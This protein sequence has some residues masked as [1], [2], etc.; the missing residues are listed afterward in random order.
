VLSR[1]PSIFLSALVLAC[2]GFDAAPAHAEPTLLVTLDYRVDPAL[3][4]CPDEAAFKAM[5][6]G[7]L[8]YDAFRPRAPDRVIAHLQA[9][10]DGL[11]GAIE[12]RDA[13]GVARGQRDLT[14]KSGNCAELARTMSFAIAVQIQ[15]L[16]KESG[17]TKESGIT[18]PAPGAAPAS[19]EQERRATT[20]EPSKPRGDDNETASADEASAEPAAWQ[21]TLGAGPSLG[22]GVAPRM[23]I[24]GRAFATVRGG[25]FGLEIGAEIGLPSS[26]TTSGDEGFEQHVAL[27]SLAACL[28]LPPLSGCLVSKIGRLEVRGFGVEEPRSPAG[29]V[30][31][32]GPR[33]ALEQ[34]LGQNWLAALRLDVLA[35][36]APWRVELQGQEIWKAPP[37]T[38]FVGIDVAGVIY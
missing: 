33:F 11:R 15:L 19:A 31:L 34:R 16:A 9:D 14:S 38:L 8:A 1:A 24:A 28:T 17:G 7:Q 32:A 23:V 27:G 2:L 20:P 30:A 10:A 37:I 22:F 36:L 25:R 12:W 3:K 35:T 21:V 13:A 4:G 29:L 5:V 6:Q 26:H 18:K